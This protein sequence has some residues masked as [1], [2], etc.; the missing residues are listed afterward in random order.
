MKLYDARRDERDACGIGFVADSKGRASRSIVDA[1]L[2]ALC[3]VRHRGAV[4][5]DALTGDGAGLLLPIP[6]A[7]LSEEAGERLGLAMV[8]A[9]PASP[10]SGKGA[11]EE[12]CEIEGIEISGWRV[13]PVESGALG[14][15]ARAAAPAI[16]QALLLRPVGADVA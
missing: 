12:A 1:A 9:D 5:A 16:L 3:R 6:T 13:V 10:E 15:Q 14:E 4:A 7:L 8:F 11:V 2:E